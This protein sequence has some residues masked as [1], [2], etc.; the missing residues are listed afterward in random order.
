MDSFIRLT[1]PD[2][3]GFD[4]YRTDADGTPR[5][6][7]VIA[8]EMYG[9]TDYI[10][11]VVDY[12]AGQGFATVAPALFD[13]LEPGII[14]DYTEA[15]NTRG[16]EL[17]PRVAWEDA[18]D[19]LIAASDHLRATDG[20]GKVAILGFCWGGT[21]AWLAACR[22][23]FDAA[24]SYYGTSI[25]DFAT[26]TPRCPVIC[27]IG[28]ADTVLPPERL[29]ILRAAQP[30]LPIKLYPGARHGFDNAMRPARYDA[31]ATL[32][33]RAASLEFLRQYIG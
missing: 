7:L 2:G 12:W 15:G 21:L 9:L 8:Q 1:S 19:D 24:V 32:A 22:R 27:N 4:A 18:L 29:D 16:K 10:L 5:G 31:D 23:D 26:E 11:S 13:R 20:V 6:G 14:V 17:Y 3:H 28:D 33:G 25:V 30:D